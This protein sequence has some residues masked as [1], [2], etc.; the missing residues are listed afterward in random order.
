MNLCYIPQVYQS[1]SQVQVLSPSSMKLPWAI[2]RNML[3]HLRNACGHRKNPVASQNWNQG[4]LSDFHESGDLYRT[5]YFFSKFC[6]THQWSTY[7]CKLRGFTFS[8]VPLQPPRI[9]PMMSSWARWV[10]VL[11][12]MSWNPYHPSAQLVDVLEWYCQAVG[13]TFRWREALHK[14]L[15]SL[16]Q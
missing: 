6:T 8:H 5:W 15:C 12:H 11:Y 9:S 4:E 1:K 3:Q 10:V 2:L 16:H 7:S 14:S 13:P